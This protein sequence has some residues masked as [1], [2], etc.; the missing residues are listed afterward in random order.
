VKLSEIRQVLATRGL[1]LTRSLGQNF[2]HD[3]NQLRRIVAAAALTPEDSV[4]EI[5]PG[6][7]PLTELLLPRTKQVLAIEKDL[8]L[9]AYLK[10]RFATARNLTLEAADALEHLRS[11]RPDW[12]GWKVV[13]N[14]PYSVASPLLVEL[15]LAAHGPE[16]MVVT[17]QR[18]VARRLTARAGAEDYGVLSLLAQL[19]YE[20]AG[21]FR[22]PA[23][24]FFPQPEV[25]S[26]CVTLV[27][28]A[29]PLLSAPEVPLFVQIVKRCFSQRRKMMF[30]LLKRDWPEPAVASAFDRLALEPQARAEAVGLEQFARLARLL[31]GDN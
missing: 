29:A 11:R 12:R 3:A 5:G 23:T 28:R 16:R 19:H 13:S 7:G 14:L 4:L 20:A 25:D 18:E 27:R 1:R 10:E 2:L 24:C 30:N 15:A 9:A 22:I 8:R 31:G 26:A 6:L 21:S 17:L